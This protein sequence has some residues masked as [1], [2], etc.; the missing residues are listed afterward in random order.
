MFSV[1]KHHTING[2][3]CEVKKALS[4][5]DME[6]QRGGGGGGGSGGGGRGMLFIPGMIGIEEMHRILSMLKLLLVM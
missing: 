3:H 6:N 5:Q 1:I 2:R 4:R